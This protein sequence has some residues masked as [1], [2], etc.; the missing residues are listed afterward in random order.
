M[1]R[2]LIPQ[3]L[4]IYT[5]QFTNHTQSH[6]SCYNINLNIAQCYDVYMFHNFPMIEDRVEKNLIVNLNNF[7]K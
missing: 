6:P 4:S 5:H 1:K 7:S 2:K 3:I